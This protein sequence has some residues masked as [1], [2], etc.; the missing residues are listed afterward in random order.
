MKGKF[1]KMKKRENTKK[2]QK[3]KQK[4]E[5][6]KKK[7]EKKIYKAKKQK[8]NFIKNEI[9]QKKKKKKREKKGRPMCDCVTKMLLEVAKSKQGNCIY[10][11]FYPLILYPEGGG[12]VVI[13]ILTY[14]SPVSFD[15]A[16]LTEL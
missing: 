7:K 12:G 5:K 9:Q 2:K 4:K 1:Q 14:C 10:Y 13:P 16:S 6:R 8:K 11:R 15:R 3:K